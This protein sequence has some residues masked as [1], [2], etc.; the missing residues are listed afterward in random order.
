MRYDISEITVSPGA[1]V[2][3]VFQN[4]DDMPHNI[5]FCQ[6][7]TDVVALANKQ[8]DQ[9]EEA[10]K[11]NWIPNDPAVWLH[12]KTL[13]PKQSEELVFKAPDKPGVYPFVCTF[14]GH[15][16]TM[17]GKL[18]VFSQG[19]RLKDLTFRL[20]H[21]NWTKLPKFQTL[22]PH[23]EGPVEDN[24]VQLKFD[25]Y[26]NDYGVV[27][28]GKLNIDAA[29]EYTFSIAGDD[30]VR[31]LIDDK[32]V[33]EHDGIHPAA[34]IVE[35]KVKLTPGEHSFRLEYFQASGESELFVAWRG[36]KFTTTPLSKWLHPNWKTGAAA[37]KKDTKSPIVL[38]VR[39][40]PVI[41]RNFVAGAGNRAIAVGY[42]G[43]MNIAWSAERMTM[44]LAWRGAF[45]DAS[46]HWL[47]RGAGHQAP[48]GFDV[49]RP[50]EDN[51]LPF[52]IRKDPSDP[53]PRLERDDRA[54]G[55][56][57]KGYQLDERRFPTFSYTWNGVQVADRF[58][59]SGDAVT[60]KGTITRTL[61]LT[62]QIPPNTVFRVA[63]G[64]KI[65]PVG[66]GFAVDGGKF[67][68]GGTDY[69]NEFQV[70]VEGGEISGS[71]HVLVPARP[72]I[73][74]TY[75]WKDAGHGTHSSAQA[76]AH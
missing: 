47:D 39:E 35:G 27:F 64:V 37:K 65:Q 10:L 17:Q 67:N 53:W 26:K 4:T 5:V 21:G 1:S 7:G 51:T 36:A 61:R 6:P 72:E 31:L 24:L 56:Q 76:H 20:Y 50:L 34:D 19:G 62:G 14:P 75:S 9:P 74:I 66:S 70:A 8:L 58:D 60:G 16:M 46:K 43:G 40:E 73:K 23:R 68:L 57:W 12:S 63:S 33:A 32:K 45:M 69:G 54:E 22:T 13:D 28:T 41:Y 11:R 30:G 55:Y 48:L 18:N 15:A 38:T 71:N 59:V 3:L 29:G 44:A 52:A 25:D 42:P 49:F 2:K